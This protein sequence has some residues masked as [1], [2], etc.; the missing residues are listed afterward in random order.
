MFKNGGLSHLSV[1]LLPSQC[2][3]LQKWEDI[4]FVMDAQSKALQQKSVEMLTYYWG[5]MAEAAT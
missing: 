3:I 2:S 4:N 5:V 1:F